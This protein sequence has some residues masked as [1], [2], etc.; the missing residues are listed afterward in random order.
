MSAGT[1][2]KQGEDLL[3][4]KVP[5]SLMCLLTRPK[6]GHTYTAEVFFSKSHEKSMHFTAA[7]YVS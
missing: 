5:T 2:E 1:V 3:K 6:P 4:M 7:F